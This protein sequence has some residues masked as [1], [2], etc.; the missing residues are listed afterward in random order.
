MH[1]NSYTDYNDMMIIIL[2]ISIIMI[3][4]IESFLYFLK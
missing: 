4:I 1:I 3:M 2:M